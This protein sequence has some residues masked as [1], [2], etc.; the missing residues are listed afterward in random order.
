MTR[1]ENQIKIESFPKIALQSIPYQY[2]ILDNHILNENKDRY[3]GNF[4]PLCFHRFIELQ[5]YR[6]LQK[7]TLDYC[8]DL[9]KEVQQENMKHLAQQS[10]I[11]SSSPPVVVV[12]EPG[13]RLLPLRCQLKPNILK[14]TNTKGVE[15]THV[16]RVNKQDGLQVLERKDDLIF[17]VLRNG[18]VPAPP[19]TTKLA[20]SYDRKAKHRKFVRVSELPTLSTQ[21]P[22]RNRIWNLLKSSDYR[23]PKRKTDL[24][25][26]YGQW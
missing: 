17:P 14:P 23:N 12:G 20:Q 16:Y 26:I 4:P 9:L 1:T 8:D 2:E 25:R 22:L 10:N 21:R 3:I 15:T 19:Q 13:Q 6:R 18:R 7:E 11:F 5:T 24:K